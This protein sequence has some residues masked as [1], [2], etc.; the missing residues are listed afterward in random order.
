MRR[1]DNG[2]DSACGDSA[3]AWSGAREPATDQPAGD[4]R[5]DIVSCGDCDSDGD[6]LAV[7]NAF[8]F[9]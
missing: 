9:A 7:T 4:D 6:G 2:A 5:A 3:N 1:C 8:A